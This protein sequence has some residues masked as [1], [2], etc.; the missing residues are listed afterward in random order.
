MSPSADRIKKLCGQRE[1]SGGGRAK[2]EGPVG[3]G[4]QKMLTTAYKIN[5]LQSFLVAQQIKALVVWLS[6]LWLRLLLWHRFD[7][8][9]GNFCMPCAWLKKKQA[10]RIYYRSQRILLIFYNNYKCSTT[11]KNCDSLRGTLVTYIRLSTIP[12][13]KRLIKNRKHCMTSDKNLP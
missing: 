7:P 1:Q 11:F 12:Q 3:G 13:K 6:L 10:T 4:D 9:P 2:G 8:W 5:E